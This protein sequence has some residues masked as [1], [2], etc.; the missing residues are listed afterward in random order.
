MFGAIEQVSKALQHMDTRVSVL[1]K[2]AASFV[3]T[4][5]NDTHFNS[6][7]NSCVSDSQD[8][9][10]EPTLPQYRR[11]PRCINEG[12]EPHQFNTPK[13][14]FRKQYFEVLDFIA[15]EIDRSL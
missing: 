8:L 10:S 13:D 2:I 7:Y 3:K 1:P 5:R 9:T 6:F 14:Y 11:V 15:E 4:Q 12:S